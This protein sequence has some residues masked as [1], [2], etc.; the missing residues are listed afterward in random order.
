MKN[1]EN[2]EQII[3]EQLIPSLVDKDTLKPQIREKSSLPP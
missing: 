1:L 2:C 3:K